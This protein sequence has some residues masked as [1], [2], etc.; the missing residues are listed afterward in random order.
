MK[1]LADILLVAGAG[2]VTYG[3]WALEPMV[4]VITGGALL[5]AAG[6]ARARAESLAEFERR[7]GAK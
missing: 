3:A 4:G 6:L 7:R 5:L 1:Y 2:A